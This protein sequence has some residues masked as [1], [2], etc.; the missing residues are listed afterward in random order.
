MN[1][2]HERLFRQGSTTYF[3]S[4]RFFPADVRRD[5]F[6]L[7]GFVRKAD[8]FVDALPQDAD[9]FRRYREQW[10]HAGEGKPSGDP[11]IDGFVDLSRRRSFERSWTEAFLGAMEQDLTVKEYSTLEETI[12]YMYGSAEVIGLFMCRIM[13]LDREADY[14]ARMLGRA[15]QY[16]NFIRDIDEDLSLGR[17][18]L[19]V[20]DTA[21]ER[22]DRDYVLAHPDR[23]RQFHRI[24]ID[25]YRKWQA[26]AEEGY[27]YIPWRYLVPIK[28]AADSYLWTAG[29]IEK[30]PLVVFRRKIKPHK[31]QVLLRG[32]ANLFLAAGKKRRFRHAAA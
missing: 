14:P 29:V 27:R 7:Y 5:V 21:L 13:G 20:A 8:N 2:E 6:L 22:L 10:L 31:R 19:P 11:V 4:T 12:G 28:T 25:R 9:G 16:I 17:R 26:E 23:F 1:G 3:N 30:D 32:M 18:Y 15:M 24:Q